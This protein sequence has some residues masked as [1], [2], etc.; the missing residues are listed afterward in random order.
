MCQAHT[1]EEMGEELYNCILECAPRLSEI[2]VKSSKV[3]AVK[4]SL[5]CS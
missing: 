2:F 1:T 5:L 4:V 3:L